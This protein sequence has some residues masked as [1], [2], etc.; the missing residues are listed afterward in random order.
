MVNRFLRLRHDAVIGSNHQDDDVGRLGAACTHG[1]EGL[2]TWRVEEGDHAAA[3]LDVIRADVLRD[4]ARFAGRYLGAT[5]VIEQRCLAVIDVTHDGHNRSAWLQH[6]VLV[7]FAGFEE[8]FWIVELGRH[9]GVAQFL[10]ENHRGF[11]VQH[12]VDGHH[13]TH[14]HHL[15]DQLGGLDRHLVRQIG[16]RDGFGHMH[17]AHDRFGRCLEV[18]LLLRLL[19]MAIATAAAA[20][21]TTP[22]C[23]SIGIA[24][25]LD[26]A[27][28]VVLGLLL[29][30]AIRRLGFLGL[31]VSLGRL[32][33]RADLAFGLGCHC[34]S[35]GRCG[36]AGFFLFG[37][38][39][40]FFK[41]ARFFSGLAG[42]F[43]HYLGLHFGGLPRH[44]FGMTAVCTLTRGQGGGR[45]RSGRFKLLAVPLPASGF[46]NRFNDGLGLRLGCRDD[47]HNGLNHGRD[48]R[49]SFR[50]SHDDFFF[51]L[52]NGTFR[53]DIGIITLDEYALLAHLDLNGTCLAGC[54]GSLDLAGLLAC[55]RDLGFGRDIAVR[56]TQVV[57]QTCLV[58]LANT[59]VQAF[60][61]VTPAFC[62]CSSQR[63]D[64]HFQIPWRNPPRSF[65]GIGYYSP[66][67]QT[68]AHAPW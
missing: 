35:S 3:G 42:N 41:L 65:L 37:L 33:Q 45:S 8:G 18:C 23:A 32:V 62:S 31:F 43:T 6:D 30:V 24:A 13:L 67:A 58:M 27:T 14:H 1:R 11:L 17:F 2:V 55:Q 40:L 46:D 48:D 60:D 5:N 59:V 36:H 26:G 63:R 9:C 4:A 44:Q 16:N 7:L 25:C 20:W 39:A 47:F 49:L 52:G 28:L 38:E 57:E 19:A 12:L 53:N 34:C 56:T 22:A 64:R 15:L 21:A 50:R 66:L 10:D 68:N 61:F 29:G 54:V 51:G